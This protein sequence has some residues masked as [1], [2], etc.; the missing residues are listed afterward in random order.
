M[1]IDA[2]MEAFP[3]IILD[4]TL[5]WGLPGITRIMMVMFMRSVVVAIGLYVES[6]ILF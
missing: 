4:L 2:C 3:L 6:F 5:M 1:M